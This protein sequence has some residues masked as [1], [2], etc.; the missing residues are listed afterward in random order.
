MRETSPSLLLIPLAAVLAFFLSSASSLSPPPDQTPATAGVVDSAAAPD[1]PATAGPT[2]AGNAAALLYQ[3]FGFA[4]QTDATKAD[5][6]GKTTVSCPSAGQ[7]LGRYRLEFLVATLPDPKESRLNYLFDRNLDAIQRALETDGYVL[8]RF[9]LPWL[10]GRGKES[11]S[12]EKRSDR[13]R[14]EPGVILFRHRREERLLALFLVGETPTSGLH[15]AALE[16]ALDQIASLAGWMGAAPACLPTVTTET[17]D[18]SA[19]PPSTSPMAARCTPNAEP[20][21][22]REIRLMAPTFSGSQDSLGLAL[23]NW[24]AGFRSKHTDSPPPSLRLISGSATAVDRLKLCERLSVPDQPNWQPKFQATVP[25]SEYGLRDFLAFLDRRDPDARR[26]KIALLSESNTIYG[27]TLT[28][29]LNLATKDL[30]WILSIPFPL[31]I[32]QLRTATE[33]VRSGRTSTQPELPGLRQPLLPL[34]LEDAM[35][36]S[37]VV[38][39]FSQLEKAS[40][41]LSLSTLLAEIN[42]EHIRYVGIVATDVLDAVFLVRELRRHCPNAEIFVFFSDLIYLRPELHTDMRGVLVISPYSLF[43]PNQFWTAPFQGALARQQFPTW[44]TQGAYNATLALVGRTQS[45][46]EYGAPFDFPSI[47]GEKK[48]RRPSL[49]LSIVGGNTLWPLREIGPEHDFPESGAPPILTIDIDHDYLFA[50]PPLEPAAL[51]KP[52][53]ITLASGLNSK[54]TITLLLLLAALGVLVGLPLILESAKATAKKLELRWKLPESLFAQVLRSWPGEAFGLGVFVEYGLRL[55]VYLL[56]C[57]LSLLFIYIPFVWV[58]WLSMTAVDEL[59]ASLLERAG[60]E[61]GWEGSFLWVV[62]VV[63]LVTIFHLVVLMWL[64]MSIVDWSVRAWNDRRDEQQKSHMSRRIVNRIAPAAAVALPLLVAF[65]LWIEALAL[66]R[67]RAAGENVLYFLRATDL[68]TGVSP[69]TPLLLVGIAGFACACCSL[70]RIRLLERFHCPLD[71]P[72]CV[73]FL[74]FDSGGKGTSSGLKRYEERV[75]AVLDCHLWQLPA[76]WL[77]LPLAVAPFFYLFVYRFVPT[78]EGSA[79]DLIFRLGFVL[80]EIFLALTFLRFC[81]LWIALRRMLKRLGLHPLF[82]LRGS[83][84][85]DTERMARLPRINLTT[86]APNLGPLVDSVQQGG[87]LVRL[88]G[89]TDTAGAL[90]PLLEASE[91]H[92]EAALQ[93]KS[94]GRWRDALRS[95]CEAQVQL[96]MASRWVVQWL[97]PRWR[98]RRPTGELPGAVVE[99]S[100]VA[101]AQAETFLMSRIAAFLNLVLA[102]MQN[103]VVFV[104]T[105]MILLLMAISYYPFQPHD[106][107]LLFGWILIISVVVATLG[108]FVQMDRERVLSLFTGSTPGKIEWNRSFIGRIVIHGLLPILALLNA[109][110]PDVIRQVFSWLDIFQGGGR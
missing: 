4:Q 22:R 108:I 49:W 109:Q 27:S 81:Y 65:W 70:R 87:R 20:P 29:S 23:Q 72:F 59:K 79:F 107:I 17:G 25:K 42:R 35:E 30:G 32:S 6:A 89:A 43:S 52:Y 39:L 100:E 38:P 47:K 83:E 53:R 92:L 64:A 101:T 3:Y 93:S 40:L 99:G 71:P 26:G 5:A 77:I 94:D 14:R 56:G 78:I 36:T 103:L 54:T 18:P 82:A 105:G 45:M 28:S 62:I 86:P 102:Q 21:S 44:V 16:A 9:D 12:T 46:L 41:E 50:A 11:A 67:S 106:R 85:E 66:K 76:W 63:G 74:N 96:A 58:S 48:P 97:E 90:R 84:K 88:L 24:L 60:M 61:L 75:V 33:R 110:F 69:L 68:M 80:V 95:R 19:S 73:P 98:L 31:H 7:S 15:K 10:D 13:H 34:Q 37:E 51:P 91:V 8:D 55:R 1:R 2:A 104:T 57:C